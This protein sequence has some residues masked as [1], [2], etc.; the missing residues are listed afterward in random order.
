[1]KVYTAFLDLFAAYDSV[2]RKKL[3]RYLIAKNKDSTV[4]ER[5]HSNHV[6]RMPIP[7]H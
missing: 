3:W 1:M 6:L 2:P 7:S 5:Y 4:F